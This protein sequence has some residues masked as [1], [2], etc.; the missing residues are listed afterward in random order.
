[1]PLS[2]NRRQDYQSCRYNLGR[3]VG[4]LLEF[5]AKAGTRA[6]IEAALG[7]IDRALA[8]DEAERVL[9]DGR[10]PFDLLVHERGFNTWVSR[11]KTKGSKRDDVLGHYITFL[12]TCSVEAFK[13][14][15]EAAASGYSSPAVWARLLGVGAERV[16]DVC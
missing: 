6:V 10:L 2:S 13:E 12:R 16:A 9:I 7:D 8:N 5:S 11:T 1:M 14:S 3:N 4:R 15:V